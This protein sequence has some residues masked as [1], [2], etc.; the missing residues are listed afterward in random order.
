MTD[1]DSKKQVLDLLKQEQ[2][3]KLMEVDE[4]AAAEAAG[5]QPPAEK[6]K[7]KKSKVKLVTKT[8][9][10]TSRRA[11]AGPAAMED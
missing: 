11:A 2:A 5:K 8:V 9:T 1:A 6:K 4:G 3:E 10:G 7:K